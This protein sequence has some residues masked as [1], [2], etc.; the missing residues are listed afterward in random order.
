LRILFISANREICGGPVAP[1]GIATLLAE[2]TSQYEV[3]VLDLAF[4][5]DWIKS[6]SNCCATYQPNIIAISIRNLDNSDYKSFFSYLDYYDELATHIKKTSFAT[7][8]VGGSGFSIAPRD[9]MKRLRFDYGIVGSGEVVLQKLV[10]AVVKKMPT[11]DIANV[12]CWKGDKLHFTGSFNMYSAIFN[13]P[14][15]SQIA[16]HFLDIGD[17]GNI[18]TSRGCQFTCCYCVIPQMTKQVYAKPI[19]NIIIE[20][21]DMKAMGYTKV[22]FTDNILNYNRNRFINL[23]TRIQNNNLSDM[24][25]SCQIEPSNFDEVSASNAKKAGFKSIKVSALSYSDAVLK[26]NGKKFLNSDLNRLVDLSIKYSID[27]D[28]HFIFGLIN[29]TPDSV[30][31]TVEYINSINNQNISCS[32]DFGCRVFENTPLFIHLC[33]NQEIR[34]IHE[35]IFYIS[36]YVKENIDYIESAINKKNATNNQDFWKALVYKLATPKKRR[37]FLDKM[38]AKKNP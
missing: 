4:A 27:L 30:R 12:Y 2:L 36:N 10:N 28:M 15:R 31:T 22:F 13:R 11:D 35:P 17:M 1:L 21:S 7:T 5:D 8:I 37:L 9:I 6:I 38:V 18:E 16:Q 23:C 25:Y 26:A 24:E 33:E 34:D 19:K 32:Y 29:E 3:Q 20:L 14:D